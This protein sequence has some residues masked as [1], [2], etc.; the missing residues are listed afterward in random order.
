MR[1]TG[2]FS[3]ILNEG[4]ADGNNV[5]EI[6]NAEDIVDDIIGNV[7]ER[8]KYSVGVFLES[9]RLTVHL[10]SFVRAEFPQTYPEDSAAER[11][12]KLL[13]VENK[14]PKTGVKFYR[15][16]RDNESWIPL[17]TVLLQNRGRESQL[18][19]LIP[20]LTVNQIKILS[21]TDRLGVG[22]VD[23]GDG[24]IGEG[25]IESRR[26]L[27]F[28]Q[29]E[30]EYRVDIDTDDNLPRPI[31]LKQGKDDNVTISAKKLVSENSRRAYFELQNTGE[32]PIKMSY[33]QSGLSD[34]I[35]VY[36]GQLYYPLVVKGLTI[37]DEVW[38]QAVNTPS[39]VVIYDYSLSY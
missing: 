7:D 35:I 2:T 37:T 18:S 21:R 1:E 8:I 39:T 17:S 13:E 31:Y 11:A 5:H 24:L 4:N 26:G 3:F 36:P 9:L 10:P 22:C 33:S 19:V 15:R 30:G 25:S 6:F 23:Y 12:N 16:K 34:P 29:L 28:V 38:V 32:A 27:D 14:F 20:Y